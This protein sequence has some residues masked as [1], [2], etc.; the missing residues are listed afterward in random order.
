MTNIFFRECRKPRGPRQEPYSAAAPAWTKRSFVRY[1][2]TVSPPADRQPFHAARNLVYFSLDVPAYF[3]NLVFGFV[4]GFRY[5]SLQVS[6]GVLGF[7]LRAFEWFVNILE[8]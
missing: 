1:S 8:I 3:L 4:R 2:A 5:F 7:G 6:S